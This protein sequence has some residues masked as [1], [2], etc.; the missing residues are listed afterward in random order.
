MVTPT[1]AHSRPASSSRRIILRVLVALLLALALV[2]AGAALWF[3]HAATASLPQLDGSVR[4]S[5]LAGPVRV[6]RDAQGVPHITAASLEDL[7]FAQG[8]VTAQDRL[9]QM[10]VSRRWGA[11][12]VSEVLGRRTLLHDREQRILGVRLVAERSAAALSER[13][14]A[15]WSAYARGVNAYIETHRQN[16]PIEFRVLRYQPRP[17]TVVD[18]FLCGANMAQALNHWLY[19]SELA[20]ER[21]LAKLGPELAADLYPNKSWRD[22]PP[23]ETPYPLDAPP[24]DE[25]DEQVPERT[26]SRIP[27]R[28]KKVSSLFKPF[29]PPATFDEPAPVVPGSN[30][31]AISGEHTVTGKPLLSND[32]HLV[33]TIPNTW[34]EAHLQVR[35]GNG[36]FDVAGFTIP[37]MP[38]VIVGHNQR[39]AWGFT[40]LGPAVEDLYVENV[41]S[42]GEYQTLSG[43]QPLQRRHEVIHVKGEPDH[44]L[45][46]LATR[47]GPLVTDLVGGE[48]RPIALK[49]TLFDGPMTTPFFDINAAQNWEQFRQA[50]AQF[51]GPSQNAVYADV[52]GHI[53]YQATGHIPL[54]ASGDGSLPVSGAD[55]AHEWTG[56]IPFEH[57][58]SVFDPPNG[59]I[60][61]ANGR[62]APDNYLYVLSNEWGSPYRTERI[63]RLLSSGKKFAAADMLKIQ[64]D[65]FSEFDHFCADRF[66]YAVDHADN[67]SPQARAAANMM[68]GWDGRVTVDAAAPTVVTAVRREL[69]RMLLEPHLGPAEDSP[70][71]ANAATNATV[72]PQPVRGWQQ[73]SWFM[74]PV[75]LENLLMKRPARWLPAGYRTYD[76]LLLAAVEAAMAQKDPPRDFKSTPARPWHWGTQHRIDLRHPLFGALPV[77]GRWFGTGDHP[78]A[79]DGETVQQIRRGLGPSERMTVD[80][81]DL[82]NSNLNIVTGESGQIFSPHFMDQWK[83]WY[84]G[85]SFHLAFSDAA[86]QSAKRHELILQPGN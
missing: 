62:I 42:N 65:V 6:V 54:R 63:N 40:N 45:E 26:P 15:Y 86:V 43:W 76:E 10:D 35:G 83:A 27:A 72:M 81:A 9:W 51:S 85:T 34:Y 29:D 3:Y 18:S 78:L 16:L 53:G 17:W 19:S 21:V 20:H 61:T 48:T 11:G 60:V 4:L 1:L 24:S 31:W 30:N 25:E 47:H 8:Y 84:E 69:W 13:D 57:L 68:R 37:G 2:A 7:F 77:L 58:P 74:S 22:H 82:D 67:A 33:N 56:Y 70:A 46:V 79:G 71:T 23:G 44:G 38:F 41:N 49:W 52:D 75:A 66:V 28:N 32:M 14:R 39:I 12:E 80:F 55:D 64:T 5:G 59:I 36:G 50:F 73:Y